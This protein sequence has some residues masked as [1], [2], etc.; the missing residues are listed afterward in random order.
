MISCYKSHKEIAKYLLE[1][2]ADVNRRSVKGNTA[3][4]DCAESGSLEIMKMLLKGGARM[5]RD[6]YSMTPLLA[7]SV[8]GHTN[9]VEYLVH[10]PRAVREHR[11]DALELL[12]A[13]FVDKN[14]T[15]TQL[16]SEL[17]YG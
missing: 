3:L 15:Q 5:E 2:G 9:I 10:Q 14:R 4:H 6:G 13:T 1:R 11:I 7:A 12:G 17:W 16:K 8:T